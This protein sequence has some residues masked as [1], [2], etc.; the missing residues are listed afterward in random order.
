VASLMFRHRRVRPRRHSDAALVAEK[1]QRARTA[2]Y[3]SRPGRSP[4]S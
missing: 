1:G 2:A 4:R 3:C